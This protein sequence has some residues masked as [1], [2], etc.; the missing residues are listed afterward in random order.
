ML[1]HNH[2]FLPPYAVVT[3]GAR[4]HAVAA[5]DEGTV[6]QARRLS[7][8]IQVHMGF[9]RVEQ[10]QFEWLVEPPSFFFTDLLLRRRSVVTTLCD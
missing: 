7:E 3:S 6:R 4:C 1:A 8:R 2:V 10:Q 5:V 9:G